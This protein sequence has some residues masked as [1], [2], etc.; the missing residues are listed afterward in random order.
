ME[1]CPY[2]LIIFRRYFFFADW[3]KNNFFVGDN[4]VII[5]EIDERFEF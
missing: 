1:N 5:D 4:G 3:D 2:I